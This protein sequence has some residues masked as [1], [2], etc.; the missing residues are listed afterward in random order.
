[1]YC[2]KFLDNT[3]NYIWCKGIFFVNP[4]YEQKFKEEF[5][6]KKLLTISEIKNMLKC[7]NVG[8]WIFTLSSNIIC[9]IYN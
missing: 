2:V 6:D 5:P 7:F 4:E 8:I 9:E 1:M 3:V